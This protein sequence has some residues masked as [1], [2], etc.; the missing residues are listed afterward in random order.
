MDFKYIEIGGY[1]RFVLSFVWR[2]YRGIWY[3]VNGVWVYY[4]G[5]YV[6]GMTRQDK[7][8]CDRVRCDRVR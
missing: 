1:L 3:M 5:Y 6:I 4:G 8:R 2:G 7:G